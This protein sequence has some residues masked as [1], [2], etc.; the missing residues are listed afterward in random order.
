MAKIDY[1]NYEGLKYYRSKHSEEIT[2]LETRL[3]QAYS[4][5]DTALST[6]L[7]EQI[8]VLR[9]KIPEDVYITMKVGET[10]VKANGQSTLE[11]I[12]GSNVTLTPD[13]TN[14]SIT[15]TAK[16][17][18]YPMASDSVDGLLSKED[19]TT[20][21]NLG[22]A[23]APDNSTIVANDQ[24]QLIVNNVPAT[25][26]SGVLNISQIPT[27]A[28]ER[29]YVVA[30]KE[31]LLALTSEQV[32]N[33]DTVKVTSYA[34]GSETPI[35]KMFLVVDESKLGTSDAIDA[36]TEYTASTYWSNIKDIPNIAYKGDLAKV[37]TSGSY[38]DLV[39]KP[40]IPSSTNQLTNNG[41]P[42]GNGDPYTTESALSSAVE[43]INASIAGLNYA[44]SNT[45]GGVANSAAKLETGTV[46]SSTQP[47]Y[48]NSEGVPVATTYSLNKTVPS[49]AVFTDTVYT[50]PDSGVTAGTYRSVTVNAQGHVTSGTNPTTLAEYGIT[51][52]KIDSGTIT[53][54]SNSITPLTSHQSVVNGGNT[55]SW[56]SSVTVGTVGG[57][58]LTFK[59]PGNPNTDTWR[60]IKVNN[61]EKIASSSSTPL[62]IKAGS[63]ISLAADTSGNVVITSSYVNTTYSAGS[64]ISFSG[65]TINNS[66]VRSISTGTSNGTISVNTG[67]STS[68]V[69]VYGLG[70]LA[71]KDSL[72]ASDVGALSSSTNY[73]GSSSVGGPA[74]SAV[75]L[76][77]S[78]TI[79][80]DTAVSSTA[81]GFDGSQNITIPVTGVKEA[82]LTWG[83]KNHSG[84]YGP[85]DA[86]LIPE[87][88]ANRLAF[89][90]PA[91][92]TIEYSRDSGSTWT[93]YG[94]SDEDK[95]N[96]F[97]TDYGA[98]FS[99]GKSDSSNKAT[100]AY[101]LRITIDTSEY[102]I[103]TVLNKFMIYCSTNGSGNCWCTIEASLE[104]TP[105]A[106]NTYAN[107]ASL[108]GWSGYNIINTAGF[109]TYGNSPE[110]QN[111]LVRFTFG[112]D[113]VNDANYDG[114]RILK[115]AAFGGVGWTEPSTL[116]KYGHLYRIASN[117]EA[118]FPGVVTASYFNGEAS[119]A[120][121]A[122]NYANSGTIYNHV[123]DTT[124]HIT[125]AERTKWN[126][127]A[128]ADLRA[129]AN[130]WQQKQ[131]FSAAGT[132]EAG[133]TS[134]SGAINVTSGGIWAAGGIKGN[135]VYNAVWNDLA[136]C[137]PVDDE[138]E[139]EAGRCYCFDGTHY[140]KSDRYLADGI[141]GIHSDTYGMHMGAKQGVKQMDVA[142][143]GFVLAYV[144]TTYP[145]GTALTCTEDGMLTAMSRQDK[146]EYPEKI[147]AI[148][149]KNE[150]EE[151]WGSD[152][153]KVK[154]NG[155]RWVKV[156]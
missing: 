147:V 12:A 1:L 155:R 82:Y 64:G 135:K 124:V 8:E 27:T 139:L 113:K 73:A 115:I 50:H 34:D 40:T 88:S 61:E 151:Y 93:D 90:N 153:Q 150:L 29:L 38:E 118:V 71:Y 94:A 104:S 69:S 66:G 81:V 127:A 86:S 106:W 102:S 53:L 28:L 68:N 4:G 101:R 60:A 84:E 132:V 20:L 87:L 117:Q 22:A 140:Y 55:A 35:S 122:S 128:A 65:T 146:I 74:T 24:N 3:T 63:N 78:K 110:Y 67:G 16:D 57:T 32:Q 18:T 121:T 44:G 98:N 77:S 96:L 114:L 129:L 10:E 125:A 156:R 11:L 52:A 95:V 111:G 17:T 141:I 39:N 6:S 23:Y 48:F 123:T 83:G 13:A 36:F 19:Y 148:Y 144:D 85:I 76:S 91:A 75:K 30:N 116:A 56:G 70:N 92:I 142:V 9:K 72:S 5:A 152:T 25:K 120:A 49:D 103:Y 46:G 7:G 45:N 143:A 99:I 136:D 54:G 112:C 109:S 15:I 105:T 41:A 37:A 47:V 145:V 26:I 149:W 21:H 97:S 42:N 108:S 154:V 107:K 100:T 80:L 62:N 79:A 59:M 130:K 134:G 43:A 31:A 133:S 119:S 137:I 126:N 131:E 58:A 14:K 51:D 138:V 33:G 2:A 89:G